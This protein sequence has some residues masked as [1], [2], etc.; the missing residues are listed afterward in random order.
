[1]TFGSAPAQQPNIQSPPTL[2][3]ASVALSGQRERRR[4]GMGSTIFSG[5]SGT[6]S[7]PLAAK[8]LLGQ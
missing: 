5:S 7:A 1:M 3:D 6:Q 4:L 2:A 8:S